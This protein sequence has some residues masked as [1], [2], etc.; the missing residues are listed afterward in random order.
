MTT[1]A[2]IGIGIVHCQSND[3]SKDIGC[4][5]V[6][7]S[8]NGK[9]TSVI[10]E[11]GAVFRHVDFGFDT[12]LRMIHFSKDGDGWYMCSM[13]PIPGRDEEYRA[14]WVFFPSSLDLSQKDIKNIIE[15]A[16]SQ[17]KENRF[18]TNKLQE[19]IQAYLK[20]NED[21]PRYNVPATQNGFAF[22]DTSGDDTNLNLYDLYGCMYQK[23]FV[24]YEWVILMNKSD[25]KLKGRTDDISDKKIVKSYIIKP[26]SN[27]FGFEPYYRG[28]V[29]S[30]PIRIMDGECLLVEF[31]KEGYETIV[32]NVKTQGDFEIT[33]DECKKYF[34]KDQFIA[35][36]SKTDKRIFRAKITPCN[37][38]ENDDKTRWIFSEQNLEDTEFR[39]SAEGY[40]TGTFKRDLRN[41]TLKS[42]ITFCM[43]PEVH[44]YVF[45]LPLNRSVV[46]DC[47]AVKTTIR[48]QYVIK[49]SPFEG[50]KCDG[51][52]REGGVSNKLYV[53]NHIRFGG[54]LE[55]Q[56]KRGYDVGAINDPTVGGHIGS[57]AYDPYIHGGNNG[58]EYAKLFWKYL[59]KT[60]VV[61]VILA[62]VGVIGYL[63]YDNFFKSVPSINSSMVNTVVN[64]PEIIEESDDNW[65]I[66]LDYLREHTNQIRK[67]GMDSIVGLNGLYDIVNEYRFK[68]F[69]EYID[70]KSH[71]DE[72]LAIDVWK[73]L[74]EKSKAVD[75]NKPGRYNSATEEQSITFKKYFHKA[76]PERVNGSG[77]Q[78]S[79]NTGSPGGHNNG[80][81]TEQDDN[82]PNSQAD[83]R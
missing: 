76:F 31:K 3:E 68:D 40:T 54:P 10:G 43:E 47:K 11:T 50:Y 45:E 73:R 33:V 39:V 41:E 28:S 64:D 37:A 77:S 1:D 63:V 21:S 60:G 22:R 49:E 56:D 34:K 58:R 79:G 14:S 46:K 67:D 42:E 16:E 69:I 38:R 35:I 74:Y 9:W 32:R 13:K 36:D 52:P 19:T 30:S 53:D 66:A 48:S 17:I 2:K 75:S 83:N 26:Q 27:E 20:V 24:Q 25:I 5:T 29:F 57:S 72:I 80:S 23:E 4:T 6:Y 8:D 82:N 44:E 78:G 18:D 81:R 51:P 59:V 71:R 15:V 70:K 61:I 55:P 12:I 62:I 65:K 7:K